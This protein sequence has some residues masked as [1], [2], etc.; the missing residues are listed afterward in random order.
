MANNES[1]LIGHGFDELTAEKQ[2][3]IASMGGKASV[4]ARRQKKKLKECLEILLEKEVS[5][6][7]DG[8]PISGTEGMAIRA[9][10]AALQGDW[11]AWELVR[12]TSGQ[13][14]VDKV[15][16]SEVDPEVVE[17]IE[18]MVMESE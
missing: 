8:R 15:V 9:I 1:N 6:D 14:P 3:N 7:K 5:K 4:E 11:K 16:V 10:Q 12:D 13:K 17:E 18:K 2:R